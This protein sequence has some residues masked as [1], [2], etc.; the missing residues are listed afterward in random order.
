MTKAWK[1]V[2]FILIAVLTFGVVMVAGQGNV[3]A[4]SLLGPSD[5]GTFTGF[6]AN[7]CDN[8]NTG[9]VM[10]KTSEY[11]LL[12]VDC[13]HSGYCPVCGEIGYSISGINGFCWVST[14]PFSDPVPEGKKVT[15]ITATVMQVACYGAKSIKIRV[16][17]TLVG[18]GVPDGDCMCD[19][20]YPLVVSSNTYSS[21]FPGYVYGG[22]NRLGLEVD[23]TSGV[24]DV[25][26]KLYYEDE[27]PAPVQVGQGSLGTGTSTPAAWPKPVEM[28]NIV[29]Q[30]ATVSIPTVSPGQSVDVSAA[31]TN[32]G[33]ASGDAK[34]SL[35]INGEEVESKGVAV[36]GGQTTPVNFQVSRNEPGTYTVQVG[37]VPA[38]SFTV[39]AF[40]NNDILI[41][42]IIALFALGIAGTLFFILRRRTA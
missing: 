20:C 3:K 19:T 34:I 6:G 42:G 32:K 14:C 22:T 31:V 17:N 40:A 29:V 30:S 5:N 9:S 28:S 36:A 8:R 26:V 12:E 33:T 39:D 25:R 7:G 13:W 4:D 16:N 18:A 24:S 1:S 37:N 11:V 27:A 35:Y 41:Y 15:K 21:G 38:G 2:A 10:N 23:G